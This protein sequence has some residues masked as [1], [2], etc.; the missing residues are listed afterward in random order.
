M[1][2]TWEPNTVLEVPSVYR[3]A[4]A[5]IDRASS[6]LIASVHASSDGGIDAGAL[7]RRVAYAAASNGVAHW[8]AIGDFNRSPHTVAAFAPP[9]GTRIYNPAQ[10]TH[11]SGG[12]LDYMASN[13]FTERWQATVAPNTNSDHWPVH[14]GALLAAAGPRSVT[15]LST[16]LTKHLSTSPR[17]TSCSDQRRYSSS[18]RRM[19]TWLVR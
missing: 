7:L 5:I 18:P 3:P 10:P 16:C 17:S 1:I 12:E 11:A 13:V 19:D 2:T 8:V 9:D 14:F 15:A 6:T 4:L